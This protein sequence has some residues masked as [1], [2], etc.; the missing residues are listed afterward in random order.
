MSKW[1]TRFMLVLLFGVWVNTWVLVMRP[2][3]LP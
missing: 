1:Q 2:V 3:I